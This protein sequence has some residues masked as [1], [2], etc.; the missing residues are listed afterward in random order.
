MNGTLSTNNCSKES[1]ITPNQSHIC[2][3]IT[4]LETKIVFQMATDI[5]METIPGTNAREFPVFKKYFSSSFHSSPVLGSTTNWSYSFWTITLIT[6]LNIMRAVDGATPK[7]SPTVVQEEPWTKHR[8][9]L[10]SSWHSGD[11]GSLIWV[12]SFLISSTM[13]FSRNVKVC[14]VTLSRFLNWASLQFAKL[15]PHYSWFLCSPGFLALTPPLLA[16]QITAIATKVG[17]AEFFCPK[18]WYFV[19]IPIDL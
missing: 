11:V 15:L 3:W 10:R 16:A 9:N 12:L 19:P 6:W 4:L 18:S 8:Y 17:I 2:N 7:T 13:K 1:L 14:R 5:Y